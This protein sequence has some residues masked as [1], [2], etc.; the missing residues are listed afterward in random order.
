MRRLSSAVFHGKSVL[1]F[2]RTWR[3]RLHRDR[4]LVGLIRRLRPPSPSLPSGSGSDD[5]KLTEGLAVLTIHRSPAGRRGPCSQSSTRCA[6]RGCSSKLLLRVLAFRERFRRR[7]RSG[8]R[9]KCCDSF[10]PLRFDIEF[11]E[12]LLHELGLHGLQFRSSR[13]S[14]GFGTG[15][16]LVRPLEPSKTQATSVTA[17]VVA[18]GPA[19]RVPRPCPAPGGTYRQD[20][21]DRLAVGRQG[22][23]LEGTRC[24]A[25]V[26]SRLR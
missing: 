22:H 4:R 3:Q 12:G 26:G 11:A 5:R 17:H 23:G 13:R 10:E 25:E 14:A 20:M 18:S 8:R 16:T 24:Q 6:P 19:R 15:A 9:R 21:E 7:L 2:V 1:R